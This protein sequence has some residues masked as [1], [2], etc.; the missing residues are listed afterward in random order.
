MQK[1]VLNERYELERKVGEGG[2][3]RIY[4]GRDLR[5]NRRVAIKIPHLHFRGEPDFLERFRHEAQAA[6]ML[7]HPNIVDVYDVGQDGDVHY[8]VMEYVEGTDLKTI[9]NREAPL[10]IERAVG[11]AEQI[12]RGLQA[13]HQAGM[14]HRDIKPQNVIVTPDGQARVTDFGVA[15]SHLSTA[16]T[17]TGVSFGTVDYLSP[18]QAQGR[19][20]TAQSDVYALGVVL[21]E[22]LT[23]RLPFS[24][25]SAVAIA[26]KHVS[27]P[28]PAPR[29]LNPSITPGLESLILRA[30]AKDPAQRPRSAQEFA[31]LLANYGQLAQQETV[32]NQ[33]VSRP[34][35][36]AQTAPQTSPRAASATG[37]TGRVPIP[38]PRAAPGRAPRQD[39]LGCGVFVVGMLVLAGVLGLIY[40]I[41]TGAFG[42]LFA[43]LGGGTLPN[44]PTATLEPGAPAPTTEIQVPVPDLAGLTAEAADTALQ[45]FKLVPVRQDAYDPLVAIGQVVSQE[46]A[47][48]TMIEP[49]QPVTYT[50]SLGPLLV[51]VPDVTRVPADLAR[52]RLS[53][54]GFPVEVVEESSQTVDAGFVIRQS[55]SAGLRVPQGQVVTLVVSR[56]DTVRFPDVIGLQRDEAERQ[57]RATA[58]LGLKYVDEQGRDR[59][60]DYDRYAVG[61]VVSAQTSDG[62]GLAN[63]DMVPRGTE[64]ILGVKKGE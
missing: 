24:G 5:L 55:P 14:V 39:G 50:V 48:G 63:G 57:I 27:E 9:I 40:L 7:S 58:G 35:Q 17:E 43:G 19:P 32:L 47:P 44:R 15:K 59:L 52:Q 2:M 25:D 23:G 13:A 49:S 26:M 38:P 1:K 46:I 64:I 16:L 56:G 22:M 37:S 6:A 60:P 41:G 12:A 29:R 33:A 30:L 10:A 28:P 18:E 34:Q 36:S 3:A 4:A 20:A 53:G 61:E 8:I 62:R 31:Q 21:F 45:Q 42:Q 11:L 51:E 54:G